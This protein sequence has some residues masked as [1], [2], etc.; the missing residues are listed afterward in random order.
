MDL[1]QAD[2]HIGAVV[3]YPLVA[4]EQ[5]LQNEPCLQRAGTL[6]QPDNVPLPHLDAQGIDDLLQRLHGPGAIR[7]VRSEDGDG[8]IQNVADGLA[9]DGQLL[10]AVLGQGQ[11]F[12][13]QLLGGF[14]HIDGV[15]RDALEVI[16]AVQQDGQRPA[17]CFA[18][19]LAGELDEIGAQSVFVAVGFLLHGD[20]ALQILFGEVVQQPHGQL[21]GV[22]GQVRHVVHGLFAQVHGKAGPVQKALVQSLQGCGAGI[23][24]GLLAVGDG[25]LCQLHQHIG[26]GEEHDGAADIK[27]AVNDGDV[28]RAGG[29]EQEGEVQEAVQCIEYHKKQQSAN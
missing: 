22:P 28:C 24:G 21:E 15:V 26:E 14:G 20:D 23:L 16:D 25:E 6:A 10:P 11:S 4:G 12:V 19:V 2:G 13:A 5:V 8:Q 3:R 18:Q 7:I 9:V 29:G 17:V 27:E 1:D